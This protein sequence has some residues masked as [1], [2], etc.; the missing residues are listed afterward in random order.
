LVSVTLFDGP[1][2]PAVVAGKVRLV[3]E[4]AT[5]GP[6]P[7]HVRATYCGVLAAVS[8]IARDA[9]SVPVRSG[10]NRIEMV[11]LMPLDSVLGQLLVD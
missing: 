6:T 4:S 10:L 11:Q 5:A 8:E 7:V 3:S 1:A 9:V 2:V